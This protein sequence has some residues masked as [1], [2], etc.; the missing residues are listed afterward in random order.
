MGVPLVG[1]VT[2]ERPELACSHTF[3]LGGL[4]DVVV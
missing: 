1:V 2:G 3:L 4:D